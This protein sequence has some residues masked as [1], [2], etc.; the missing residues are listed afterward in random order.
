MHGMCQVDNTAAMWHSLFV[1]RRNYVLPKKWGR[2]RLAR[3]CPKTILHLLCLLSAHTTHFAA[4]TT[5]CAA[6]TTSYAGYTTQYAGRTS[7]CAC[8]TTQ[9]A[10]LTT[11]C[12]GRTTQCAALTTNFARVTKAFALLFQNIRGQRFTPA[13]VY[14]PSKLCAKTK[15]REIASDL[16]VLYKWPNWILWYITKWLTI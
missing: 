6:H 8:L 1:Y 9:C 16:R 13:H 10:A 4:R 12:A 7:Q 15:N 11:Q 5:Y 3:R 14:V 2:T